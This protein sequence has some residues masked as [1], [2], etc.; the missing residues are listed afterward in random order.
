MCDSRGL[1]PG[2]Q[3]RKQLAQCLLLSVFSQ[4]IRDL[5]LFMH[6]KTDVCLAIMQ[7]KCKFATNFI[8]GAVV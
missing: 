8:S 6:E 1:K 2:I 3:C 4:E 7:E 5:Q